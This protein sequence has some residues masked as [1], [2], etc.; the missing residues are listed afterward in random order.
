M[1]KT[2]ESIGW[3]KL[4]TAREIRSTYWNLREKGNSHR[5][6]RALVVLAYR[7]EGNAMKSSA[8][9]KEFNDFIN[10]S[11]CTTI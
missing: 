2:L 11:I 8:I 9:R 3:S 6:A 7:P 1:A 4:H 5:E 10:F